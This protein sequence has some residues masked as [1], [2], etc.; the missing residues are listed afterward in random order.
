MFCQRNKYRK[1]LLEVAQVAIKVNLF[2][3]IIFSDRFLFIP[4]V[5]VLI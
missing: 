3:L 1:I 5:S 4:Q 2:A